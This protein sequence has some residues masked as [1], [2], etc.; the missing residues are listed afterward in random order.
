MSPLG[1]H[2]AHN[3]KDSS[4]ELLSF[5]NFIYKKNVAIHKMKECKRNATKKIFFSEKVKK[6]E[7]H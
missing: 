7:Q 2:A 3:K 6:V 4:R 1:H 5:K